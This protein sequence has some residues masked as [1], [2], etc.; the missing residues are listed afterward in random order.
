[1]FFD[2]KDPRYNHCTVKEIEHLKEIMKEKIDLSLNRSIQELEDSYWEFIEATEGED[3]AMW[4][5]TVQEN[6]SAVE[7]YLM[8]QDRL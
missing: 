4:S 2:P 3:S 1:M 5:E 6:F 8:R 7:G